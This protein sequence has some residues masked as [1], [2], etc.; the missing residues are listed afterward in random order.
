MSS[1]TLY[2]KLHTSEDRFV[3]EALH[4]IVFVPEKLVP[5]PKSG[6]I[7]DDCASCDCQ[8]QKKKSTAKEQGSSKPGHVHEEDSSEENEYG[9]DRFRSARYGT[10]DEDETDL[11]IEEPAND[12]KKRQGQGQGQIRGPV[13]DTRLQDVL[14]V[15]KKK[16]QHHLPI[17]TIGTKIATTAEFRANLDVM[18]QVSGVINQVSRDYREPGWPNGRALDF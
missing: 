16:W 2:I 6:V 8:H 11:A 4:G 13:E 1:R 5:P 14:A 10:V 18:Q 17:L 3:A 9:K 15:R 12:K 7:N